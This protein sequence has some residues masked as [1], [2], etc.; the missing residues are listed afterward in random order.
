M[1]VYVHTDEIHSMES[2]REVVP[3][4]IELLRPS[5]VLDVGCGTGTWLK[6]FEENGVGDVMGIDDHTGH[7]MV[8][9]VNKFVKRDVAKPFFLDRKFDLVLALEVAEHLEEVH[10]DA[11]L[12]NLVQHGDTILF[13]AA[14]PGQGGQ[15]HVNEQ[16]PDYWRA[17]FAGL[18]YR[19]YDPLRLRLW[20]ND[21]I[22]W[23]YK[24]NIFVVSKIEL[25]FD[26]GSLSLVHP[27]LFASS[28]RTWTHEKESILSGRHGV[29]AGLGILFRSL[30][31]KWWTI[32]GKK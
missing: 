19:F 18:G 14:V 3:L 32:I 22:Q 23:W 8:I 1:S 27:D 15:H 13:S 5:S 21:Q 25:P 29:F 12:K 24:Q 30:M 11:F 31:F 9:S 2:P 26:E 16:W 7:K 6:A 17:R 10:V 4:V 20:A 28:L